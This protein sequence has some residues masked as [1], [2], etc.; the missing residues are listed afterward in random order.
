MV[1]NESFV[2]RKPLEFTLMVLFVIFLL[3][4][5]VYFYTKHT[6]QTAKPETLIAESYNEVDYKFNPE[7]ELSENDK[8][9]LF[10]IEYEGNFVE[11]RGALMNCE[12]L[13]GAF[14]V[15]IDHRG[16]GFADVLFTTQQDCS[17]I[18]VGEAINYKIRLVDRKSRTFIGTDGEIIA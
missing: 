12:Q 4:L 7:S 15:G 16:T 18:P 1:L 17:K 3:L 10:K 14:K 9:Q 6:K 5:P 8:R 2:T 11:W 13:T